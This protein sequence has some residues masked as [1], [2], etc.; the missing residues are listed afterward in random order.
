MLYGGAYA[1]PVDGALV[2]FR[3]LILSCLLYTKIPKGSR[4]LHFVV[5]CKGSTPRHTQYL[6][7]LRPGHAR[8]F[9]GST[10]PTSHPCHA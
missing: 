8:I 4:V 6:P 3:A 2:I 5:R 9:L 7:V 1:N 10:P